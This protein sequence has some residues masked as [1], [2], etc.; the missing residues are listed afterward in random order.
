M[1]VVARVRGEFRPVRV[2][3]DTGHWWLIS[4]STRPIGDVTVHVVGKDG[5]RTRVDGL[6]TDELRSLDQL[7]ESPSTS[8][9]R[10]GRT[11]LEVRWRDRGHVNSY[12]VS[13]R[14]D[15]LRSGAA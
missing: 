2:F 1:A 4:V 7:T 9:D 14:N 3:A 15:G 10:H 6:C 13:V 5:R 11:V 12:T 8:L